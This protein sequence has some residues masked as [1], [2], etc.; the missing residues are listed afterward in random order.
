MLDNARA[1]AIA[2]ENEYR[3]ALANLSFESGTIVRG[4]N[5]E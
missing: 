5:L 4:F 2:K 3:L 1:N